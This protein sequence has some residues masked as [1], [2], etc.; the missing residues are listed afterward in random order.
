MA[1]DTPGVRGRETMTTT[2]AVDYG[3]P[4]LVDHVVVNSE[5]VL[6]AEVVRRSGFVVGYGVRKR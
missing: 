6:L 4:A 3:L 5:Q 2:S 1:Y